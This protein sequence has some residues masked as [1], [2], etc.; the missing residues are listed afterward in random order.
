MGTLSVEVVDPVKKKFR[1]GSGVPFKRASL[2]H[3]TLS[4]RLLNCGPRTLSGV[5]GDQGVREIG[6]EEN[7]FY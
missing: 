7:Y 4:H 5:H 2:R 1:T 6:W 3:M